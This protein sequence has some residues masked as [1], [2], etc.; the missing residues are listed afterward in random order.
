[1]GVLVA[2][3]PLDGGS[4]T[5]DHS[6]SMFL[7]DPDGALR[8]L[9]S[10]PLHAEAHRGRLPAD[11][12]AHDAKHRRFSTGDRLFAALQY[13][14]PKHLLSR[15]IYA[16]A[17]SESSLDQEHVPAH[18][19]Q[20]L[21]HQH[22]RSRATGSVRVSHLQRFLHAR[23]AARRAADRARDRTSSS[24]RS[25]ARSASAASIEGDLLISGEGTSLF[26]AGAA[27]R[28]CRSRRGVSRRQLRVHLSCAVQLSPHSHAVRRTRARQRLRARRALQRERSDR[29]RRPARLRAQ[30]APDLR[31]RHCARPH[32]SD[33]RRRAVRR[34]HR[35]GTLRRSES[36][37]APA[38][39]AD[40][41]PEG[42]RPAT[43]PRAR[44]SA[45][46]TWDRRSCCCSSAIASRGSRRWSPDATVQLGRTDRARG[47]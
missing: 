34:Q 5:V 31:L 16:I 4:Y 12:P 22:G 44:S 1:M 43:S 3:R 21:S 9:F 41:H 17:R 8:A 20:R 37:A 6:T 29:A 15:V 33:P 23:A 45:A 42:P 36:A 27:G 2:T 25:T 40:A 13:L 35:D 7:V 38:Q 46:S 30:R 11:R 18:L 26:A 24:A 19:P 28:R 47:A 32:G 14:L 10:P 39:G